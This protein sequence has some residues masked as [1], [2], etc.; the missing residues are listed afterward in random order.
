MRGLGHTGNGYIVDVNAIE[1]D[2]AVRFEEEPELCILGLVRAGNFI[3]QMDPA[4]G[5]IGPVPGFIQA[6]GGSPVV[7]RGISTVVGTFR[8]QVRRRE[9]FPIAANASTCF[10]AILSRYFF[11]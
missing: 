1:C 9:S 7:V 11:L 2:A 3:G 6:T 5:V 10:I 4:L 8:W